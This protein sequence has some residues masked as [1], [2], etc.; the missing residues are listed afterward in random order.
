MT[1]EIS[2][3]KSISGAAIEAVEVA[4]NSRGRVEFLFNE[5]LVWA[6]PDD[7]AAEVVERYFDAMELQ[8]LMLHGSGN[9]QITERTNYE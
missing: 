3:G 2:K 1:I 8:N 9:I 5:V 7:F 6:N 4:Y